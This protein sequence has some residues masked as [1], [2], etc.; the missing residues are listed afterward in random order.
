MDELGPGDSVSRGVRA[1]AAACFLL[2]W[3]V[4]G[5]SRFL[6]WPAIAQGYLEYAE[7]GLSIKDMCEQ[8]GDGNGQ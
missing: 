2:V 4:D 3:G 5:A 6:F 1:P 8:V 7:V